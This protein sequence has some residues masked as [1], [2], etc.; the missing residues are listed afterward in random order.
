[1]F[2]IDGLK[3][4]SNSHPSHRPYLAVSFNNPFVGSELFKSHRASGMQLLRADAD[5]CAKSE[6]CAVGEGGRGVG[7]DYRSINP[8]EEGGRCVG[9]GRNDRFAVT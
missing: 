7:V 2:S 5:L 8:F 4:H 1:M 3:M 6:L 9:V